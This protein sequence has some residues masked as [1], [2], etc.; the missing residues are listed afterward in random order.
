MNGLSSYEEEG[1]RLVSHGTILRG[2]IQE[3]IPKKGIG[4]F[5]F[6]T[7]EIHFQNKRLFLGIQ[8]AG[9]SKNQNITYKRVKK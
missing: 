9:I 3:A 5:L 7:C 2:K 6:K 1:S 4:L 8:Y